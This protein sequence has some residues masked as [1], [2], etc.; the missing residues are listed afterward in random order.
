MEA[1]QVI[2]VIVPL[3][4]SGNTGNILKAISPFL[5]SAELD[6]RLSICDVLDAL[7]KNDLDVLLVVILSGF[8]IDLCFTVR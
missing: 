5:V 1:L 3:L 6:M 2:R 4:R 7:S 8:S